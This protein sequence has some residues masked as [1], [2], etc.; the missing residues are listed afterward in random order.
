MPVSKLG[1]EVGKLVVGMMGEDIGHMHGEVQSNHI[2]VEIKT[3][4]RVVGRQQKPK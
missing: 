2:V 1:D 4:W 3:K